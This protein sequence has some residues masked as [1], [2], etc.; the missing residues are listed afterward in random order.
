MAKSTP[1]ISPRRFALLGSFLTVV[2]TAVILWVRLE[3]G[4][5][6]LGGLEWQ[7]ISIDT[8][9]LGL[10][11][12]ELFIPLVGLY[13]FS[14]TSLFERIVTTESIQRVDR[15]KLTAVLIFILLLNMVA[16]GWFNEASDSFITNGMLIVL[17]AGLLGGWRAGLILG[18]ATMFFYGANSFFLELALLPKAESISDALFELQDTFLWNLLD[19]SVLAM[20]WGGIIVGLWRD[21]VGNQVWKPAGLFIIGVLLEWFPAWLNFIV[22]GEGEDVLAHFPAALITGV[23]LMILGLLVRQAQ[24]RAAEKR[25]VLT[26]H[27]RTQAELKALRAQ[28]N[29]HFLFNALSTIRYHAR[30]N[31]DIAYDLLDDL[32]DIFHSALRSDPF[33]SLENELETAKSYL[34][35]EQAR[36]RE[37]LTVVWQIDTAV[38]YQHPVPALIVQPLVENAV[39]HG[40]A[41]QSEGGSIT[42]E[43]QNDIEFCL[44][45][46]K[47][48]GAGF[49]IENP[50]TKGNGIGLSNIKERLISLYGPE[51]APQIESRAGQGTR[52]IIRIPHDNSSR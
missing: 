29:P 37:R 35:I 16:T 45:Q 50:Q 26:E 40:I 34:A 51:F 27:A 3:E 19:F 52:I 36:L 42:I 25:L 15:I 9:V 46:I 39:V 23:A 49:D 4:S 5:P 21:T 6:A 48:D 11:L 28:I 1:L 14:S 2:L 33:V 20:L 12:Q 38:D 31:P 18:A 30:T 7:D 10:A 24:G 22:A 32:S 47:D 8:D 41:P 44:I 43:V 13:L 17:A